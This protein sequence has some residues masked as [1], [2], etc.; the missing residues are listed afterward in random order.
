MMVGTVRW[1]ELAELKGTSAWTVD[2]RV[3]R[4]RP[5]VRIRI[6]FPFF[7]DF[8]RSGSRLLAR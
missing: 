3:A 8:P 5:A 2:E 7:P 4:Q 1:P 6:F